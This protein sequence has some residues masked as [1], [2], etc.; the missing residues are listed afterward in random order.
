M[1]QVRAYQPSQKAEWDQFVFSSNNGTIFHTQ[2]FL[3]YHPAGRFIFHHLM[4]YEN[5]TLIALLPAAS[6]NQNNT[7]ISPIG[8][9][10]GGL[11]LPNLNYQKTEEIVEALLTHA[12]GENFKE[13]KL[14]AAPLIY[15]TR[16]TQDLD[17]ALAFKGFDFEKHFISHVIDH[18]SDL[19]FLNTFNERSRRYIKR[20]SVEPDLHF[21]ISAQPE[22]YSE[23]YPI[24]LENKAKHNA[25]P[26]HSLA[27]LIRLQELFPEAVK[28]FVVRL[29]GKAIAA[30]LVFSCNKNSTLI[31]YN[32]LSYEF[33]KLRPIFYLMHHV[34]KW[35]IASGHKYCDIGV[36]QEPMHANPMTPSYSLVEFKEKFNSKGFLRST[37]RKTL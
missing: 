7:L 35:S 22:V 20:T 23:V 18:G 2:K 11:V 13:I 21:E 27:E 16:L 24:L 4:F 32:M 17:Y 12:N 9:S 25:T 31:F 29:K 8:S 3:S 34:V 10:Y 37:F 14:T 1:I 19:G 6:S 26:T 15:Q 30:S 28:L 5:N 36:S 33:E